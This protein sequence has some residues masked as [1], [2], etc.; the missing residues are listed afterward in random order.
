MCEHLASF[1]LPAQLGV[2]AA[3]SRIH[4]SS[5][6]TFL[7]VERFDRHGLLGR[8][9]VT[10]GLSLNAALLGLAGAPWTEA[11]RQVAAGDERISTSFRATCAD[12]AA[13][14]HRLISG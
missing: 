13:V 3:A 4:Q 2:G 6:R 9:G 14:L 12:N 11:A 8:S 7:E 10:S 1:I 5:G